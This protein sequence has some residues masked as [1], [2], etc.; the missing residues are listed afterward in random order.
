MNLLPLESRMKTTGSRL[1]QGASLRGLP[2]LTV[3]TKLQR[4]EG[5]DLMEFPGSA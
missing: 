1:P 5:K 4:S 3:L 2:E